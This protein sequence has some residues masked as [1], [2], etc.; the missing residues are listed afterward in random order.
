MDSLW[1]E[2]WK[3]APQCL[4]GR[5]CDEEEIANDSNTSSGE[6]DICT[7][8]EVG[9]PLGSAACRPLAARDDICIPGEVGLPFGSAACRPLAA[10]S[11][12]P[13]SVDL[14]N[15]QKHLPAT[16]G[17]RERWTKQCGQYRPL[18]HLARPEGKGH[19]SRIASSG[20]GTNVVRSH[21]LLVA[22]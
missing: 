10:R 22:R 4:P 5:D 8:G 7:P 17:A 11:E 15:G 21:F 3:A 12:A 20:E 13:R 2:V 16:G 1:R 18:V 19:R 9:L 6:D 14:G